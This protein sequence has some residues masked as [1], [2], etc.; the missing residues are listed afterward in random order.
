MTRSRQPRPRP[1]ILSA[2]ERAE[3]TA[4]YKHLWRRL[5]IYAARRDGLPEPVFEPE[6]GPA[7][8]PAPSSRTSPR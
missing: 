3:L 6:P 1:E 4:E 2:E 5:Q 8:P 7:Q